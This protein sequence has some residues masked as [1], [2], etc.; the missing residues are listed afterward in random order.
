VSAKT[1]EGWNLLDDDATVL[2]RQYRYS[3][4]GKATALAFRGKDGIVVVSPSTDTD[5]RA[6]DALREIGDV[7]ALVANNV[8]HH[9]GQPSWRRRF[10]DAIS[11]AP[12]ASLAR[13]AKQAKDVP[14]R[15]L[16]DLALPDHVRCDEPPGMRSGETVVTVKTAK[17]NVWFVGDLLANFERLP[18]API[19]WL[20]SLSGSGPG[21]RLFKLAALALVRDG[22]ALRAWLLDRVAVAPP[23][24]VIP[25]HGVPVDTSDV[26]EQ[27]KAQ[28]E[29]L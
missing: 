7:R 27:T 25:S 3:K 14:F 19:S 18:P 16:A 28:I 23:S 8:F 15:P 24:V 9:L 13:L 29:R 6:F 1:I 2:W 11:Y 5:D 22:K 17:G 10:P 12:S 21:Y 26:A 4:R 20:F